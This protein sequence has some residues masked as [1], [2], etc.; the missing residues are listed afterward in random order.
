MQDLTVALIQSFQFWED[1]QSNFEHFERHFKKSL[2]GHEIDLVLLPEMFNT[3]FSMN[4]QAMGESI[5]GKSVNWLRNWA[6]ELKTTIGASLII[7]ENGNYYNR[8]VLV[9]KDGVQA[10]YNKRH[11]FRM[12]HENESFSA[13]NERVVYS[14]NGWNLMLQVCY[15]LRFPVFSRNKTIEGKKE[16]DVL[17]Y[18][19][20]WPEKRAYVWKNLIQ[21]RAIENQTY[22]IGVNRVGEDGKSISYSGDSMVVDPWGKIEYQAIP[23]KEEIKILTLK[24]SVLAE[25][26]RSFPAFLDAD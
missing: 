2:L 13:G 21:A 23:T 8:F 16:Y 25:I 26:E 19:A 10:S 20:N 14:L 22:C 17:L 7:H 5:D 12:A 6:Q 11:L 18:I 9:N 24:K 4:A 1:K 15:D 3:G